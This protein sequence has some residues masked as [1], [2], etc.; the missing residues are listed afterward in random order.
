MAL[1]T[2]P[3]PGHRSQFGWLRRTR[4]AYAADD[5]RGAPGPSHAPV[6]VLMMAPDRS[7][8]HGVSGPRSLRGLWRDLDIDVTKEDI[9][10]VR[11]EMWERFPREDV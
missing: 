6:K 9:E 3:A 1:G 11:R 8:S 7:M 2:P 10:E 5:A 4:L